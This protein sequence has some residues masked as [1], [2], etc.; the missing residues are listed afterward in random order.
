VPKET[1][2]NLPEE[3]RQ[4]LLDLAI[5]EFAAHDY[6]HAS[7]SRIVARA[8]IAKGSFYQYFEDKRDLFLYLLDTAVNQRRLDF[9]RAAQGQEAPQGFFDQLRWM[10]N[11]SVQTARAHPQLSR[12]ALRAYSGDLP[13]ADEALERGK[14]MGRDY[15]RELVARGIADGELAPD[16]D[17]DLATAI[18][19]AVITEYSQIYLQRAGLGLDALAEAD[20][21]IFDSEESHALYGAVIRILERGL[22]NP[23]TLRHQE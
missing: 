18:I 1:F 10:L 16:L 11:G 14:A 4:R 9:M 20:V 23:A 5:E 7:I 2:F 12:I 22:A 13:F 15:L 3:K 8:G 19:L 21:G 17:P 6:R